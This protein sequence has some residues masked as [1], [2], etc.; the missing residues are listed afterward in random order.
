MILTAPDDR[1]FPNG[2][3]YQKGEPVDVGELAAAIGHPDAAA[4]AEDLAAQ[5]WPLRSDGGKRASVAD[6]LT[7]VG[8][9]PQAAEAA[10]EAEKADG[11]PRK[12]LVAKLEII[13]ATKID[14]AP[15]GD[16]TAPDGA[17]TKES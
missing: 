11:S 4:L 12:T 13:A 6:V 10:I 7:S 17:D 16:E 14:P 3:S 1:S 5:G 9:D 8:D 2:P 15:A